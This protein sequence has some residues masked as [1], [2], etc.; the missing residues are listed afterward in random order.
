MVIA[1]WKP[2]ALYLLQLHPFTENTA[3][4]CVTVSTLNSK[5]IPPTQNVPLNQLIRLKKMWVAG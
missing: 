4:F 1:L 5:A 2:G 3:V